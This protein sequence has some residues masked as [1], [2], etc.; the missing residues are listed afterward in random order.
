MKNSDTTLISQRYGQT[1]QQAGVDYRIW[2]AVIGLLC[3]A[4][5]LA[6]GF[7]TPN[8]NGIGSHQQLDLPVCGFYERTGYPCPTCGMTTAFAYMVRGHVLRSFIV[9]PAGAIAALIC[10]FITI[11]ATYV[12]ISGYWPGKYIFLIG[13]HWQRLTLLIVAVIL[14]SW[15]WTALRLMLLPKI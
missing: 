4:V 14:I 11:G 7:V 10:I 1:A 6:A 15:A 9:Q 13:L 3:L 5:L 12:L 8:E 2:A